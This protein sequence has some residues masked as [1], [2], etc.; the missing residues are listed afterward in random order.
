MKMTLNGCI[1]ADDDLWLYQW[2]SISACSPALV[3]Q[4]VEGTPDGETL[5]L[6]IN[7][8]GG[9]VFAGFEMYS[10]LREAH[11]PTEAHVQSLAASAASTVM[12]GCRQVLLSPVAQVMLHLPSTWA[13]GNQE[14]LSR[15]IRTLDSIT[16]SILNGYEQKCAGRATRACLE[17]LIHQET[18]LHAQEAVDLGLADGLL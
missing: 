11:C 14:D 15:E 6:E 12:A 1:V 9:S 5:I 18:W 16:Q 3:R 8:G 17:A 13:A 2:F 4:A 10:V 7:S